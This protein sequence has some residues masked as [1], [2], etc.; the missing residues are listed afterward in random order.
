MLLKKPSVSKLIKKTNY[1]TKI[2]AQHK[3]RHEFITTPEFNKL[4]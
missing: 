2:I 1:S 4:T 3:N